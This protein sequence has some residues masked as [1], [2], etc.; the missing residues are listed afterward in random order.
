MSGS[1]AND[2]N[3]M[4]AGLKRIYDS[5]PDIAGGKAVAFFKMNFR[6]QGWVYNATLNKWVPRKGKLD[7]GRNILVKSGTLSRSI[8]IT[9]T[10]KDFVAIGSDVPYAKAHNEG[11]QIIKRVNV[12]GFSRNIRGKEQQVKS[13]SRNMKTVIPQRQFL[14]ESPDVYKSAER[15]FVRQ[16]EEVLKSIKK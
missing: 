1:A 6:R 3:A 5:L 15:E 12:R 8:R 7:P 16:L 9:R 11:A 14:G 10:G 4:R 13:F 2:A